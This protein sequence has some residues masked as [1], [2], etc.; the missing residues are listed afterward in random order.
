MVV[1]KKEALFVRDWVTMVAKPGGEYHPLLGCPSTV[2]EMVHQIKFSLF[3]NLHFYIF[4][5][6][7][8]R[9]L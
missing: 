3:K 8:N 4:F 5:T 6:F 2:S 1:E 9:K 7:L